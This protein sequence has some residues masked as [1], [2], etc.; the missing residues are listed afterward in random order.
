MSVHIRQPCFE[1]EL[2]GVAIFLL[3]LTYEGSKGGGEVTHLLRTGDTFPSFCP[4]LHDSSQFPQ[5]HGQAVMRSYRWATRQVLRE[6]EE[7]RHP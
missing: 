2:P 4:D 1:H 5:F 3:A 6:Q 7:E